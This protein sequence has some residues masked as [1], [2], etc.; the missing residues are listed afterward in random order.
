MLLS[1]RL[2]QSRATNVLLGTADSLRIRSAATEAMARFN[3]SGV[4]RGLRAFTT[5][6]S[7]DDGVVM[8]IATNNIDRPESNYDLWISQYLQ[9]AKY[10]LV[11]AHI[12][13]DD[14]HSSVTIPSQQGRAIVLDDVQ[15]LV[16]LM[17]LAEPIS[18][19]LYSLHTKLARFR[20]DLRR[21]MSSL[22]AMRV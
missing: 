1:E 21:P 12:N 18:D 6:S 9:P 16:G 11:V 4:E 7:R 20:E 15:Y 8:S 19:S 17:N 13:P 14:L 10:P 5:F 3:Q 2:A 22:P